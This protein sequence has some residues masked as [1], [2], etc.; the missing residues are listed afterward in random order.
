[1]FSLRNTF[2]RRDE[3]ELLVVSYP[4]L[5][6]L[7]HEVLGLSL[8]ISQ[9][10]F[11]MIRS[12]VINLHLTTARVAFLGILLFVVN[13]NDSCVMVVL[14]IL[15]YSTDFIRLQIFSCTPYLRTVQQVQSTLMLSNGPMI[16]YSFF[17]HAQIYEMGIGCRFKCCFLGP[18]RFSLC[19][20]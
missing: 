19:D 5:T 20:L 7:F 3:D 14:T 15:L 9:I 2:W 4:L 10:C 13:V 8:A 12:L 18:G 16:S 11:R 17:K 6:F 1:M